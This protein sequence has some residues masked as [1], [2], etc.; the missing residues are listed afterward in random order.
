MINVAGLYLPL[1]GKFLVARRAY[2]P[3]K[4][5]WEFP[6]GK[7]ERGESAFEAV[8]REIQEE[9]GLMVNPLST[10]SRFTHNY[11][12]DTVILTLIKCELDPMVQ[13]VQMDG[14]HDE[15]AWIDVH[16]SEKE[17]GA[18]DIKIMDYL[19]RNILAKKLS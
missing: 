2:G 1:Q 8:K 7:I 3:N 17:F 12:F 10:V 5:L 16:E 18:L 13:T 9:L 14:S 15:F 4:G 6:G 19:K 11:Q